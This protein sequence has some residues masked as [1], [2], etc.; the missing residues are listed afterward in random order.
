MWILNGIYIS[1]S[2]VISVL[3]GLI[4][5]PSSPRCGP[6]P[7]T[8]IKSFQFIQALIFPIIHTRKKERHYIERHSSLYYFLYC[9]AHPDTRSGTASVTGDTLRDK[10][11]VPTRCSFHREPGLRRIQTPCGSRLLSRLRQA[12]RQHSNH[13]CRPRR[14]LP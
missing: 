8:Y 9:P 3:Q 12:R 6:T 4:Q 11:N 13:R 1:N 10:R 14:L 5:P 2:L 7:C